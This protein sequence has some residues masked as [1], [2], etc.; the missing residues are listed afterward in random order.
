MGVL[1]G[2]LVVVLPRCQPGIRDAAHSQATAVSSDPLVRRQLADRRHAEHLT[3]QLAGLR[4]V[5]GYLG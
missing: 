5:G 1:S 2:L 3:R 4:D